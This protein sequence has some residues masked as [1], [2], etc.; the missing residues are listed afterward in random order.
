MR[1]FLLSF[2]VLALGLAY[3]GLFQ[4]TVS[5]SPHKP[6]SY[7]ER[8]IK[9]EEPLTEEITSTLESREPS[10]FY[11][12]RN[13]D[14]SNGLSWSTAWRELNLI[15][16]DVIIPGD[17]IYIDGGPI[18]GSMTYSTTLEPAVS[19]TEELPVT[20]QLSNEVS[21]SGQAIL[22]GGNSQ[23]LPE[24]GQLAWDQSE[25][26]SAEN[27]GIRING[28]ISNVVIDGTK[29]G[30]IVIH[31]WRETGVLFNPDRIDDGE[32]NNSQNVTLRFM[33][34]YNNGKVFQADDVDNVTGESV[35]GSQDLF[36]PI[37]SAPGIKLSGSGHTFEFLEVHDNAADAIQSNF[38]NP[39]GGVFN[40][41]DDITIRNSWF[42]NQRPHSGTDNSPSTEICTAQNTSGCDEGGSPAMDATYFNYPTEPNDRQESFN[43]CTHNDGVQIYSSNDLN[44]LA[45]ESSIMGPNLMNALILGDKGDENSTAWVN[46]LALKD[47]V[48][49]RFSN[50]ALGMNNDQPNVGANWTV[51]QVTF[52]GHFN[53]QNMGSLSL[54][55]N[56]GQDEH[57]I[58]NTVTVFGRAE[59]DDGNVQFENNCE[60]N[61]YLGSIDGNEEDPQFQQ[62]NDLEDIFEADLSIDF[63][64]IFVDDYTVTNQGCNGAGSQ[65]TSVGQ[66]LTIFEDNSIVPIVVP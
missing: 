29:R 43:W 25:L 47:V 6:N 52:Y 48:F 46:D 2:G 55:S 3:V 14:N 32:D 41:I 33:E 49:T 28:G 4:T 5:A 57:L 54:Q 34:I 59:F 8:A 21:H 16:W 12:S 10:V 44:G 24:C 26:E 51:D 53:K 63:A 17:T 35:E 18:D 19:G 61:L 62:I 64:E 37:N 11:V 50:N 22:F 23:P 15:N 40:N 45:I 27:Y 20:I 56:A 39:A 66:L 13:G 1:K 9:Q 60:Y 31:G 36:Y 30:G 58:A 38:T 7:P 65:L 42:Y